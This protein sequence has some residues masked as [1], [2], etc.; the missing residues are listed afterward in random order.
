MFDQYMPVRSVTAV[1]LTRENIMAVMSH[2]EQTYRCRDF[3]VEF[4]EK[5]FCLEITKNVLTHQT[6]TYIEV[7]A[8]EGDYFI[9]DEIDFDIMDRETFLNEYQKII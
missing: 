1:Q 8:I 3:R 2:L 5:S 6:G 7:V 4:I 9:F